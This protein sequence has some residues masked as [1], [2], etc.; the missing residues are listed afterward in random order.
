[1]YVCVG[2]SGCVCVSAGVEYVARPFELY[3]HWPRR[4]SAGGAVWLL[5]C[6]QMSLI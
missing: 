4:W 5:H 2:V 1:M 6:F 3:F